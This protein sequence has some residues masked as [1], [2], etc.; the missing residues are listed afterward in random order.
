MYPKKYVSTEESEVELYPF[1]KGSGR[2]CYTSGDN[3]I[4][5]YWGSGFAVPGD[6]ELDS[7]V[8]EK[9]KEYLTNTYYWCVPNRTLTSC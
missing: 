3:L 4:R 2:D 1:M 9:V 6:T 7:S 5:N 8:R